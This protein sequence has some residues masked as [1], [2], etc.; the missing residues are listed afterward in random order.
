MD[1]HSADGQVRYAEQLR[2]LLD[3][4]PAGLLRQLLYKRLDD[5]LGIQT[6]HPARPRTQETPRRSGPRHSQRQ[7]QGLN[8]TRFAVAL[9]LQNPQLGA[10]PELTTDWADSDIPG[11]NFLLELLEQTREQPDISVAQLLERYRDTD[12]EKAVRKLVAIPL[13]L[14]ENADI[15][16]ELRGALQRLSD[17]AR[18]A[19]LRMRIRGD[20]PGGRE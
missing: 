17:K 15:A 4:L 10:D 20:Q 5:L 6:P 2:P 11:A 8:A 1:L 18:K 12:N 13:G 19:R 3:K 7:P 14:P 9:L 16:A